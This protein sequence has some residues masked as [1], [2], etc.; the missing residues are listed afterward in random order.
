M[1][2]YYEILGINENSSQD[3]IKKAYRKLSKKYHPDVNP[4]GEE[5]FK[6]ISEAYE[7]LGDP[8]KKQQY[9]NR[10]NNPFGGGMDFDIHSM[11]EQMMNGNRRQ[12]KV[13]DK[14]I[15]IEMTPVES[16]FGVEKEISYNYSKIC[17]PCDGSGGSR[18]ICPTCS[19]QGF[20][21]QKM[22]SGA[23]QQIFRTSCGSCNGQGYHI[24]KKCNNCHGVGLTKEVETLSVTIPKNV[25]NGDFMKVAGRGD[26]D[27]TYKLRGDLILKVV[28][29]KTDNFEKVGMDLVNHITLNALQLITDDKILLKHPDGDLM[30][31]MPKNLNSDKPL[32]ILKKGYRTDNGS[33]DFYI[34]VNVTNEMD[35][36]D[37]IKNK[38][39]SLLK[40]T[41]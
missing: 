3:E 20:V 25:D 13:P 30:I 39:K 32:R 4:Q 17:S 22:G 35:I 16:Y 21:M 12:Q 29:N 24:T 7:H 37:E 11:F 15:S 18:G 8:Q 2:N 5:K 19:G 36:S 34:R 31:S 9:D 33:G 38:I 14:V 27:R 41:V 28:M 40:Q 1:K 26:F 23:F 10:K 6:E